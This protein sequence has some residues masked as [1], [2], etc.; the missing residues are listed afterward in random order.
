MNSVFGK[1]MFISHEIEYQKKKK[2]KKKMWQSTCQAVLPIELI[3]E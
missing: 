1:I 3:A 2:K